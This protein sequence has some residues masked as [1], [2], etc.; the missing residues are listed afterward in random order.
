M[1]K[2]DCSQLVRQLQTIRTTSKGFMEKRLS[3][4]QRLAPSMLQPRH[5]PALARILK[6][7]TEGSV[8]QADHIVAVYQG[9]GMC[10]L[11]NMRTLCTACHA[12]VTRVQCKERAA[13]RKHKLLHNTDIR[14][15]FN[16]SP[17]SSGLRCC[18]ERNQAGSSSSGWEGEGKGTGKGKG[19]GV[20]RKKPYDFLPTFTLGFGSSQ[21]SPRP[22]TAAHAP[23]ASPTAAVPAAVTAPAE[24]VTAA[25]AVQG[26]SRFTGCAAAGAKAGVVNAAATA[27]DVAPPRAQFDAYAHQTGPPN[28]APPCGESSRACPPPA[29][30]GFSVARVLEKLR[31]RSGHKRAAAAAATGVVHPSPATATATAK[32]GRA[33]A[34]PTAA[35]RLADMLGAW[36]ATLATAAA[37]AT[38]A[39]VARPAAHGVAGMS[40][41]RAEAAAAPGPQPAPISAASVLEA[42]PAPAAAAAAAALPAGPEYLQDSSHPLH[43]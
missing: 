10:D 31:A 15:F 18:Q 27:A 26:L 20:G 7:A 32:R 12:E 33:D 42:C 41:V 8:W 29:A 5:K 9:G 37:A 35:E 4:V 19:A 22:A 38:P 34:A 2:L 17:N 43:A 11:D 1:C 40:E 25:N 23:A 3:V 30:S 39:P 16:V 14:T 6:Q 13:E 28:P 21:D 24:A 36:D